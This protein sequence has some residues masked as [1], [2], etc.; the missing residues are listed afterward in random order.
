MNR[1]DRRELIFLGDSDRELFLE[2]GPQ[3]YE[4][5]LKESDEQE[6]ERFVGRDVAQGGMVGRAVEAPA[7]RR[8]EEGAH[9]GQAEVRNVDEL[10]M[11]EKD[12]ISHL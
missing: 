3:H 7:Q 11:C 6:A 9:G 4:E 12:T 2:Q 10:P 8:S 1:G 5:E